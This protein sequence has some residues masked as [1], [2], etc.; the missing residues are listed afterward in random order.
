MQVKS[1]P[2]RDLGVALVQAGDN[3]FNKKDAPIRTF[4]EIKRDR[5]LGQLLPQLQMERSIKEAAAEA[6][7]KAAEVQKIR[8]DTNRTRIE[9]GIKLNE[10]ERNAF[11]Q[12]PDVLVIKES[13]RITPAQ[14]ERLNKKYGTSY[15]PAYWGTFVEQQREGVTYIR[16]SDSPNYVPN[17]SIGVERPKTVV[18]TALGGGQT[19]YLSAEDAVKQGEENKRFNASQAVGI[20]KFNAGQDLE[21]QKAN[22]AAMQKY[23]D[24]VRQVQ[25]AI[26]NARALAAT[27]GIDASVLDQMNNTAMQQASDVAMATAAYDKAVQEGDADAIA[28][29]AKKLDSVTDKYEKAQAKYVSD[30]AKANSGNAKAQALIQALQQIKVNRPQLVRVPIIPSTSGVTPTLDDPLGIGRPTGKSGRKNRKR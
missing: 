12:D 4:G 18:Q 7:K 11:L 22:S 30:I 13:D 27:S 14:A 20:Q 29:A 15:T 16:P 10:E 8:T 3:F 25:V 19:G 23:G 21:A 9:T 1:S 5:K 26:A 2:W 24:D 17:T 28:A 6:E